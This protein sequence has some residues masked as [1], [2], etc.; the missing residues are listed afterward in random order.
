MYYVSIA[1]TYTTDKNQP[2]FDYW[3]YKRLGEE[4]D[5]ST[6]S[7]RFT[8]KTIF[9]NADYYTCFYERSTMFNTMIGFT[10]KESAI[11]YNV[12]RMCLQHRSF[13]IYNH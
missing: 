12:L 8:I 4:Y 7:I 6:F 10:T 2:Q 5:F 1:P 13:I 11:K 9:S 3:V